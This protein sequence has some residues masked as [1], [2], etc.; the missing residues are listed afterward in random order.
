MLQNAEL[1]PKFPMD[2]PHPSFRSARS[3]ATAAFSLVEA[4][5]S[6]GVVSFAMLGLLGVV[7]S[8]LAT[9]QT[10]SLTSAET[11]IVRSVS[12]DV[13]RTD[14]SKLTATNYR[15][16]ERGLRAQPGGGLFVAEVAAPAALAA[17]SAASKV[18]IRISHQS[19][20]GVTNSYSVVVPRPA[21][22]L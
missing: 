20:P 16:D 9:F 7:P 14:Y 18:V 13:L 3:R 19:R 1:P 6:I 15:F 10:A 17:S 11:E 22:L 5:I 21:G 12:E 4:V 8:G 2:Y